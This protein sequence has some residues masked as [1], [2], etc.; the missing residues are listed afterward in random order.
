MK[1]KSINWIMY[2][3]KMNQE[4]KLDFDITLISIEWYQKK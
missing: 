2:G 4:N 1:M 3:I